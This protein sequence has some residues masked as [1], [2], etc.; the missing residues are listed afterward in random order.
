MNEKSVKDRKEDSGCWILD[1]GF[2][3]LDAG[4]WMLDTGFLKVF[5]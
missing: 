1:S 4:F 5:E 3:M 2:W